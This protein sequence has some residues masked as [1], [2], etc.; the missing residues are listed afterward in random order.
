MCFQVFKDAIH[1][2]LS[3]KKNSSDFMDEV[4]RELEVCVFVV[5][6]CYN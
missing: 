1:L 3:Y 4:M 5:I 2:A 6:H